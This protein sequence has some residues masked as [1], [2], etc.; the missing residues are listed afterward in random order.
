MYARADFNIRKKAT[1]LLS[2]SSHGDYPDFPDS[3]SV[4]FS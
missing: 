4:S 2:F 1:A 3:Y